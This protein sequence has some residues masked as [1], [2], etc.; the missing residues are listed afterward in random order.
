EKGVAIGHV[1]CSSCHV[2]EE[3][4][5][6]RINGAPTRGEA[7]SPIR[8]L[9]GEE[10]VA[11]A[12]FHIRESLG[13]KMYR[14]FAAPWVKDDVHERLKAMPQDELAT[15][16]ASVVLAKG[17]IPRWNGS[18]FFPAKVP[19]L[20]GVAGRKYLDHTGTHANRGIGDLMRYAALVSY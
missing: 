15:L 8:H 13:E 10:N 20:I 18:V 1:N 3:P 11:T 2:R 16:N 17:V 7:S 12:P 19:D 5:G 9:V 14:S 6:T 4:D